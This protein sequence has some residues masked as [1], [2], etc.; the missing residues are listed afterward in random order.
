MLDYIRIGCAVPPVQ[1]AETARNAEDICSKIVEADKSGC[2]IVVF[3]ELAITGYTC[4]D[5]FFQ[6]A[7]LDAAVVGIKKVCEC[8]KQY[9]A[10][11]VAVGMPLMIGGQMY[12]CGIVI[13]NGKIHGIVP[14]T[15]LPNHKE[16]YERRWFSSSEDL[17]QKTV[18]ACHLG[19]EECYEIPMGRDLVFR[20]GQDVL[21]G[22]EICEDL[23]TPMPPSTM[24]ALNGAEVILNLSASNETV[25]KRSFRRD[26]VKHQSSICRCVYAFTSAG[27]TESTQDIVFSGHSV[28]AELGNVLSEND[29][30]LQTDYL[31]VQDVDIGKVRS[32][33]HKDKSVRDSVTLYGKRE[34]VRIVD[35]C[36]ETSRGDGTRYPLN[37]L[38]FIPS[39]AA[40][41]AERC[42]SIFA[43]Q[44]TGLAQRLKAINAKAVI[45][46]SGGLDSTLALLVAVE[47]MARLGR[48]MTD[49]VGITM[50]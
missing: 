30:Y 15:F 31:L 42:D 29:Q 33:R 44:A 18:C 23:W 17:Q 43:I 25:G 26:L 35:C 7:L 24:L 41:R 48:P 37:K 40:G 16:F 14:K 50:P 11:T 28:V 8:T 9:P 22:V 45:G 3:P 12:N 38:P 21:F 47:A 2:D 19:L 27:Y 4:G 49:I 6:D 20:L 1:V 36:V 39:D 34:P 5:L 46:I 13:S 10:V 32:E